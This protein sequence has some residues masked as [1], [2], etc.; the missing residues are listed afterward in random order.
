MNQRVLIAV[1]II[2]LYIC[3]CQ[4]RPDYH[5][6]NNPVWIQEQVQKGYITQEQAQIL[7][8]QEKQ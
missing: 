7:L 8:E 6:G 5:E 4:S 1:V 2:L 3:G